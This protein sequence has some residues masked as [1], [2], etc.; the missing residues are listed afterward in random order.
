MS[1]REVS[2]FCPL[3]VSRCGAR[4]TVV[5][6][7][8]TALGPDPS[9]PTG[10]ALCVK[11]K[12]APE[13]VAHPDRLLHPLRRTAPKGAPD[14]GWQE[15]TWDEALDTIAAR[16]RDLAEAHGPESVVFGSASPSTSAMSDSVDWVSRLRHAFGS[17][18]LLTYM[19]LCGWGRFLAPLFTFG[20]PVPGA[21]LPD[22]D[23]AGCILFWGY[24]PSVARLAHATATTA[25]LRRGA[26]LVVVDPRRVG[27]ASKADPWLRVRP[28]TDAALALSLTHVMI[29]NG[30]FD[31]DFVRRWTNAPFLVR[32]DDAR[33]L[34]ANDVFPDGDPSHYVAWDEVGDR[35]VAYDPAHG[36]YSVDESRL[37]LF[38]KR[39]VATA[40]G[41]VTCRPVFELLAQECGRMRPE[42]AEGITGV[43]ASAVVEAARTLWESRPVAFY[44]WSG[45][46]QQS[47][48][49]QTVRAIGQL[50]A[51]TGCLDVPGG[52]VLFPSV[53]TNPV[54]DASLLSQDQRAKALGLAE[55]PLGPA[56]FEFVTGEDFYTAAIEGRPYRARGLVNFGANLVMAHGDSARGRDALTALDFFVHADLFLSPT[57]ELADIVLPVTSAFEAEALRVGF[58]ISE[59]AQSLVQLRTPVAAPRGE[60][61]SDIQIV[62]AL[63][64]R[65]GLGEHFFNGDVDAAWQ[66]QL[67][68]SGVTLDQLRADPAGVRVPLTTLHRKYAEP[69]GGGPRGFRTPSRRIELYSEVLASHG[70]PPLPQYVEPLT[71]PR[72][73]PDLAERF[74]LILTG[75]KSL[76]FCE[77]QHR[78][79]ASLRGPAPEPQLEINP[80]TAGERGISEGDWVR[81]STPLGSVRARA[82]LNGSLDPGVVCG[83]HGWWQACAELDLP[84]YP[85]FGPDSA[86]LNLVL[87]Q[88]PSDPISGSSPLRASVC[89][90]TPLDAVP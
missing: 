2:T 62:F 61:R 28:G 46:E 57:A 34:R 66:H 58:E 20:E 60:A 49:T 90:I 10:Q 72:S 17:P 36:A 14:P 43:P 26:K 21:Y 48:A 81:I 31:L 71:S 4:A 50:Y 85:P 52:N 83:Q 74:P 33:L 25:A 13:I 51:L 37:T 68:P 53:A 40:D 22:L 54:D 45:L 6:G 75:S 1:V 47:N 29:E 42:V 44:T 41:T 67:A 77:T 7:V 86:N 64:D 19:E 30:W 16:L 87:S 88:T 38:G 3:C 5:D 63:A 82:K 23:R 65:L 24:N 55:R 8:F 11:G 76:R 12:A 56:R 15:I 70:Q 73:R 39:A 27:L 18:N 59:A 89:D 80:A 78:N 69:D 9:H 35:P 79:I 84:G 32:G